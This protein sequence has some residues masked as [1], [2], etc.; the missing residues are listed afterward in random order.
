MMPN[1]KFQT[2][3]KADAKIVREVNALLSQLRSDDKGGSLK[4]LTKV[5]SDKNIVVMVVKDGARIIGIATLY[6][7]PKLGRVNGHIEDV[8]IDGAYRGQGLGES[9]MRELISVAKKRKLTSLYLTSRP[10]RVAAHR[11]YHKVG[12]KVKETTVFK[13]SL[14]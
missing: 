7:L 4:D 12:F 1:M 14:A 3:R 11:L 6:I 5:V 10:Q 2:L 13:M 9:L 8:V